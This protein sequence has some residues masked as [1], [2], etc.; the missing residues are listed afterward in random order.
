MDDDRVV[1]L[2]I[3]SPPP[4]GGGPSDGIGDRVTRL[5]TRIEEMG[6]RLDGIDR[7][8][9]SVDD[10]LGR[11]P[12]REFLATTVIAVS[13]ISLAAALAFAALTFNIADY[14]AKSAQQAEQAKTAAAAPVPPQPIVV[15]VPASPTLPSPS[16]PAQQKPASQR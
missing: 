4:G 12:S 1:R 2:P 3:R 5:E 13:G 6:R 11:L 10:K 8:L 9:A 7:I 15:V 14:A 16:G